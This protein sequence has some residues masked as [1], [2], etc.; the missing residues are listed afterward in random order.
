[1]TPPAGHGLLDGK[2][3]VITAAEPMPAAA[4]PKAPR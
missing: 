3:V 2:V 1:V 4:W